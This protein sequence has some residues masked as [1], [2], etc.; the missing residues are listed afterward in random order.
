MQPFSPNNAVGFCVSGGCSVT[1]DPGTGATS[2]DLETSTATVAP[3]DG[4]VVSLLQEEGDSSDCPGYTCFALR[5]LIPSPAA[6]PM[7]PLT[8]VFTIDAS[9][10]PPGKE[11]RQV[12]TFHDGVLVPLCFGTSGVADPDPCVLEKIFL[13]DGD[14][15]VTVLSSQNGKWRN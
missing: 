12:R 1:T 5:I 7:D 4:G 10:V 8:F 13:P 9:L 3:G 14:L 15:R 11:L 6:A 2:G